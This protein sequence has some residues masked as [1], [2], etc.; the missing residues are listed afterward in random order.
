MGN[1]SEKLQKKIK[2][3]IFPG[4]LSNHHL[5]R[6]P[7]L[8]FALKEM[9]EF[10]KNYILQIIKNS[11]TLARELDNFG[12]AV[13]GKEKGFTESHQIVV[14]VEK[15]GRGDFV[16]KKL[17]EANI[18]LNKNIIPDDKEYP[19]NPR[20]VRIGVQEMTR[21]GMKEKEMAAI[22]EFIKRV[23]IDGE[24]I[25]IVKNKVIEFRRNFQE[26]EYCFKENE[27]F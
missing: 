11:K 13:L 16:A 23:V 4:V 27:F 9:E 2:D 24:D 10:G 21:Y 26:A 15:Q 19:G 3:K 7:P 12:F 1:I 5:H 14:N 6:I 20:G 22:A 18:I 25:D 17:E 8:Y